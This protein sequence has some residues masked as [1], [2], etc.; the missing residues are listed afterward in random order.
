MT[1]RRKV[2]IAAGR[3]GQR[4]GQ[5]LRHVARE[6]GAGEHGGFGVRGS[7]RQHFRQELAAA[8]LDPLGAEDERRPGRGVS[9]KAAATVR[10]CWAGATSRMASAAAA[11]AM[12]VVPAMESGRRKPGRNCAF[13][14]DVLIDSDDL[15]LP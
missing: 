1:A 3:D 14:R 10:R 11:V 12:S 9:G 7:F 15:G 4:G 2:G 8:P 13:S 6:G 5:V